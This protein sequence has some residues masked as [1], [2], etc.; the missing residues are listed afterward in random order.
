MST[1]E[2]DVHLSFALVNIAVF[3]LTNIDVNLKRMH[4]LYTDVLIKYAQRF[5]IVSTIELLSLLSRPN[6]IIIKSFEIS[7]TN[8][9]RHYQTFSRGWE[10]ISA[11]P[12]YT[13]LYDYSTVMPLSG[14]CRR[15]NNSKKSIF[16]ANTKR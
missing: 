1:L 9:I 15:H 3:G 4:H 12:T 16:P 5:A 11:V 14:V 6:L 13:R 2:S 8:F 7:T 10:F